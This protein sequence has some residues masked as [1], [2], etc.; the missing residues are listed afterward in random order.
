MQGLR[1][2]LSF[3]YALLVFAT[4]VFTAAT[5]LEG[6]E[7]FWKY[8]VSLV[9]LIIGLICSRFVFTFM[10]KRG[11]IASM[12]GDNASYELDDL[13]PTEDDQFRELNPFTLEKNFRTKKNLFHAGKVSIWGDWQG[14][15][16][17]KK[18][19]IEEITFY[20]EKDILVIKFEEKHTLKVRSPQGIYEADTYLKILKAKE[21]LWKTPGSGITRSFT[22]SYLAT[23]NGIKTKS[24]TSWK[25]HKY[26]IGLGLSA[27]YIQG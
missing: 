25:P 21:V 17:D 13:I 6:I 16:L 22:Y 15:G 1:A 11:I 19:K 18:L 14:R 24:N 2:A 9:I 8:P 3:F 7:S 26:D 27:I 23:K 5:T 10:K 12:S 4:F 20:H